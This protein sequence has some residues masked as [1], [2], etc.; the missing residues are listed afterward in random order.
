[1]RFPSGCRGVGSVAGFQCPYTLG[2]I[3]GPVSRRHRAV[4]RGI[5]G[6]VDALSAPRVVTARAAVVIVLQASLLASCVGMPVAPSAIEMPTESAS[7]VTT[8]E[9]TAPPGT[10]ATSPSP[11]PT[12]SDPPDAASVPPTEVPARRALRVA[13]SAPIGPTMG[14]F[15]GDEPWVA[16]FVHARLYGVDASLR[17]APEV[18]SAL[19]TVSGDGLTWEI[20]IRSDVTFHDGAPVTAADVAFSLRI[21]Q[22]PQCVQLAALCRLASERLASVTAVSESS[23]VLRLTEPF[24]PLLLE[25][26]AEA[27]I[28]PQEAVLAAVDRLAVRLDGDR[29]ATIEAQG[30]RLGHA[31][32]LT[33]QCVS[34]HPQVTCPLETA[35]TTVGT[36]LEAT[37]IVIPHPDLFPGNGEPVDWYRYGEVIHRLLA[38]ARA[39]VGSADLDRAAASLR[40]IDLAWAPIGSGPYAFADAEPGLSLALRPHLRSPGD[41]PASPGVEIAADPTA[42]DRSDVLVEAAEAGD[43]DWI[44]GFPR[45][46]V[47][48]DDPGLVGAPEPRGYGITLNTAAGS[49]LAHRGVRQ[50]LAL[51]TDRGPL[52]E[53]ATQG[54]GTPIDGPVHPQ[55]WAY[56]PTETVAD[57]SAARVLLENLGW[58]RGQ[59]GIYEK[60][61]KPLRIRFLAHAGRPEGVAFLQLFAD[62]ARRDCGMEVGAYQADFSCV[63]TEAC[64]DVYRDFDGIA[65]TFALGPDPDTAWDSFDSGSLISSREPDPDRNSVYGWSHPAADAALEAGRTAT[66]ETTRRKAYA[67]FQ[68]IARTEVPYIWGF[69]RPV[70][71]W[72]SPGVISVA[73]DIDRTSATYFEHVEDW[74]VLESTDP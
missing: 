15:D 60:A 17:A 29:L 71:A 49:P 46:D 22:S 35:V 72:L 58:T 67:S 47:A 42:F 26:L 14:L 6:R 40:L 54:V 21:L 28:L 19:P 63:S 32:R 59:D 61:G 53:A 66:D 39:F 5:G 9:A 3:L 48:P 18:A 25:L 56:V 1:M 68:E 55:S 37:G 64:I 7:P 45:A 70:D 11:G 20:P 41:S 2:W 44:P 8:P 36:F 34:P 24:A 31:L 23:L 52:V 16:R 27:V 12:A 57:P 33:G 38:D 43:A 65:W 13:L 62:I 30:D 50:A 51:C 4:T 10:A 74:Y 69:I 73:G